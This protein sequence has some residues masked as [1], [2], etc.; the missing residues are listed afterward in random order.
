MCN[1]IMHDLEY[2]NCY[3][4]IVSILQLNENESITI[5][6]V[7][8][9]YHHVMDTHINNLLS[10]FKNRN[11]TN[12]EFRLKSHEI[13]IRLNGVIQRLK[14]IT[15]DHIMDGYIKCYNDYYLVNLCSNPQEYIKAQNFLLYSLN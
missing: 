1:K 6:C 11:C 2:W 10:V 12:G 8:S 14:F 3:N 7:I 13:T 5:I 9:F 4:E 15:V